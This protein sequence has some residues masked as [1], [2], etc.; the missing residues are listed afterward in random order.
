MIR[1]FSAYLWFLCHFVFNN[2]IIVWMLAQV[3]NTFWHRLQASQAYSETWKWQTN[4]ENECK[5]RGR[6]WLRE[7]EG[8]SHPTS[9]PKGGA[10]SASFAKK[11]ESTKIITGC[12]ALFS[13]S[14]SEVALRAEFRKFN[15]L[16]VLKVVFSTFSLR[17]CSSSRIFPNDAFAKFYYNMLT[18]VLPVALWNTLWKFWT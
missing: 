11:K 4:V 8:A 2:W 9:L 13:I 18:L 1:G 15:F 3:L 16:G 5:N 14:F 7:E 10:A 6:S 12:A 17:R